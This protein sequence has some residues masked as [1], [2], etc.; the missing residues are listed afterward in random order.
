MHP[1]YTLYIGLEARV[2]EWKNDVYATFSRRFSAPT[3]AQYQVDEK[4]PMITERQ[5]E[6]GRS[7]KE[8]LEQKYASQ[9]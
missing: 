4:K 1:A 3:D 7:E 5:V 2:T 8:L 6:E 9:S